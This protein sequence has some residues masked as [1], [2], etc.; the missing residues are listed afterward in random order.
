MR[1]LLLL[2]TESRRGREMAPTLRDDLRRRGV[3]TVEGGVGETAIVDCIISAGGDG[4]LTRAIAFAVERDVPIGLVP[5][6]TFNDLART[7][8]VPLDVA[9]ACDVI[10]AGHTRT[11]DIAR[12]NDV[13]YASEASI[14]VSSRIARLQTS[15]EK[16]RYGML[17]IV[18]TGLQAFR[19]MRPMHVTVSF[20]GKSERFKTVQLTVANSHRFG[21]IFNVADAAID[22]GWLDLYS[23]EIDD[24]REALS[25]A[26]AVLRG[27][28]HET[29]GLRTFR[30][31]KFHI[32]A[33][34][35]HHISADGEPAGKTPATFEV[36][37]KALRVY[38]PQE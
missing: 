31:T 20:D 23:I 26:R 2:N 18:A 22:D 13:Y 8:N 37:P 30:S 16:R 28:R 4:T 12:V 6:G 21:G 9:A 29:P 38:V 36:L 14:G 10:G 25:V 35:R 5:L 32:E 17:A 11:I 1:A 33:R 24:A 7:L 27:Q 34:S 19:Y 15:Q 3:E